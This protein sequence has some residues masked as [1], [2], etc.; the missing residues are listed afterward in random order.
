[1]KGLRL[2]EGRLRE[3]EFRAA[4]YTS[5][6]TG[7]DTEK[8]NDA[9]AEGH[10]QRLMVVID[11]D[12]TIDAITI[13]QTNAPPGLISTGCTLAASSA[14]SGAVLTIENAQNPYGKFIMYGP[15]RIDAN[16][17]DHGLL[18]H[19]LRKSRIADVTVV[20][21]ASD[22]MVFLGNAAY[23]IYYCTFE[24]L[25]SGEL[26]GG[27]GGHGV[28][29]HSTDTDSQG[30]FRRVNNNIFSSV[31][32]QYNEG[33][34]FDISYSQNSFIECG[35]EKNNSVGFSFTAGINGATMLSGYSEH[36]AQGYAQA[37]V[38]DG[39]DDTS[40]HYGSTDGVY[41]VQ[42]IGG[43]HATVFGNAGFTG[44]RNQFG[45]QVL[46][47]NDIYLSDI[48]KTKFGI[49]GSAGGNNV[50]SEL[51]YAKLS[52]DTAT[53]IPDAIT[54]VAIKWPVQSMIDTTHFTHD[55]STATAS[56][57]LIVNKSGNHFLSGVVNY[58]A[59]GTQRLT[60]QIT[61]AVNDILQDEFFAGSYAR[62]AE[63]DTSSTAFTLPLT[64]LA[65]DEIKILTKR[66]SDDPSAV[67]RIAAGSHFS[68]FRMASAG[69]NTW[70][71]TQDEFDGIA[72]TGNELNQSQ[73]DDDTLIKFVETA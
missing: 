24:N 64:L 16:G 69:L 41:N 27:N 53:Q 59:G 21:A 47:Y 22:G 25:Q 66:T 57:T 54:D 39:S 13:D 35:A 49:T 33:A 58:L 7:T 9:L 72:T 4:I 3:F 32:A 10:S 60:C 20:N 17:A 46:S 65:G 23:G 63:S 37:N 19:G 43:R 5:G 28:K 62:G 38:S 30:L 51:P 73:R 29:I 14:Y 50:L 11:V 55:V 36:N 40:F 48:T 70:A 67:S 12:L 18:V 2:F 6:F 68:V 61:V 45:N 26:G 34:G 71:G 1:M 44:D 8:L 56:E 42:V 15:L 52:I 31:V